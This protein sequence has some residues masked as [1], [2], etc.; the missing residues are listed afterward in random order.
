MNL[1]LKITLILFFTLE[2]FARE[3]GE[4]EITT[5]DGIE[6]FQ[7]EKFYLLKKNVRIESDTFNLEA[8]DVKINFDQNLYDITEINAKGNVNFYSDEHNLKGKGEK[9]KFEVPL[10]KLKVEGLKSELFTE[11]I[12]MF[13]D[14]FIEVDNLKGDFSLNGINSKLINENIFIEAKSIDGVFLNSVDSMQITF[15]KVSDETISY[16][17]N[18]NTEMYAKKINFDN[19]ISIIELI[20]NVT[21]IRNGEKITG[22]YGTL[23]TKNNSYKIKSKKQ[24]KVKA[25]IQD[26]E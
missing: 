20:D 24:T 5:D 4:T 13:S 25:I 21:I 2:V 8:N 17:K 22:D 6:V 18:N 9:L 16:V 7:N 26:N 10:E 12:Q 14:G 1:T 3:A 19:D 11:N 15:L 23:D